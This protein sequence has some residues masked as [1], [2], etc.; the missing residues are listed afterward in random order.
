MNRFPLYFALLLCIYSCTPN[1]EK[2]ISSVPTALKK[3]TLPF[4][5][6]ACRIQ[7]PGLPD[8]DPD[9]S[10]EF[11][12]FVPYCELPGNDQFKII[13]FVSVADCAIPM[14][15][16]YDNNGNEISSIVTNGGNCHGELTM[17]CTSYLKINSDFSIFSCDSAFVDPT[18]SCEV[19]I[20]HSYFV[21]KEG[22]IGSDG[23]VSIGKPITVELY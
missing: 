19:G 21:N 9:Q 23:K 13:V 1:E 2:I 20:K 6:H 15:V 7:P 14:I 4:E 5:L 3:S 16:T 17:R 10:E 22:K 18:D 8:L 12:G 11:P